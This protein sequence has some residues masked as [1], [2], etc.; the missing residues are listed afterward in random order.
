LLGGFP[1]SA[2]PPRSAIVA[3]SGGR[4]QRSSVFAVVAVGMPVA[5]G[6][7]LAAYLP[8]AALG[9]VLLFVGTRLIRVNDIASIAR[10]GGG[11]IGLVAAGALPVIV[12]PIDT[13]MLLAIVLSL[14]S[15]IYTIA[16]PPCAAFVRAPGTTIWWPPPDGGPQETLPGVLVFSPAAP[17]AF[18]NAQFIVRR[19]NA[20][21]R[22]APHPVR[23]LVIECSGVIDVAIARL[24]DVRARAAAERTGLL[25]ALA[26]KHEFR[27]V[28]EALNA[29]TPARTP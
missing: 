23:V 16:R 5:F 24:E 10:K 27:S 6:G 14:A 4:S 3:S 25:A 26:P 18:T 17:I 15:G 8:L 2:S 9:G 20:L 28:Q 21:L 1:V 7:G 19:L 11:E 29:L 13:G 22:A 12:L